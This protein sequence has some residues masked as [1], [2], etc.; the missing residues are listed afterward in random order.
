VRRRRPGPVSR[1]YVHGP[2]VDAQHENAENMQVNALLCCLSVGLRVL[3]GGVH[4]VC[5]KG[6]LGA[7]YNPMA[8]KASLSMMAWLIRC[9]MASE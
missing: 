6:Q 4:F 9:R 7:I 1:S 8:S 3:D 2:C 5:L